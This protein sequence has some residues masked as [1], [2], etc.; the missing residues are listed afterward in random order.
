MPISKTQKV[1]IVE[2]LKREA[3]PSETLVFVNFHGLSVAETTVLRRN[4]R[5]ANVGL[6]VAKKTLIKR[7]LESGQFAGELPPL[8]GEVAI[9]YSSTMLGTGGADPL[10]P[11][12]GVRSFAKEHGD[13][14]RILGGVFEGRYDGAALFAELAA[15]PPRAALYGKLLNLFNSPLSRFAV[16][17]N[18]ISKK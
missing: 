7:A 15:I 5:A 11:A 1:A 9:A 14:P 2:K 3:V 18:A 12:R 16:A 4:L 6:V 13:R 17:L 8:E 10:A